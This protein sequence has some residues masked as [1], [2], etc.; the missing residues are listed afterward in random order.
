M[1]KKLFTILV[2]VVALPSCM[3][4]RFVM[5]YDDAGGLESWDLTSDGS[6]VSEVHGEI[7]YETFVDTVASNTLKRM[8]HVTYCSQLD[9]STLDLYPCGNEYENAF[10]ELQTMQTSLHDVF[11]NHALEITI[12]GSPVN[13]K[14]LSNTEITNTLYSSGI[15]FSDAE[16]ALMLYFV[17]SNWMEEDAATGIVDALGIYHHQ[18]IYDDGT[19][20]STDVC[21]HQDEIKVIHSWMLANYLY[22]ENIPL[23]VN[24]DDY[25]TGES[26][27][28][29]FIDE[30]D[31]WSM[32]MDSAISQSI[33][34]EDLSFRLP[35][36]ML[37]NASG[38]AVIYRLHKKVATKG[39]DLKVGDI[40][41]GFNDFIVGRDS[42]AQQNEEML[43]ALKGDKKFH[44]KMKRGN[45]EFI[46]TTVAKK[47]AAP[48]EDTLFIDTFKVDDN[49]IH[50]L[51]LDSFVYGFEGPID[52][53]LTELSS[54]PAE[55]MV[56][57][58]RSN[59]GGSNQLLLYLLKTLF[60][61]E[62][63]PFRIVMRDNGMMRDSPISINETAEATRY[64]Q[65]YILMDSQSLSASEHFA[66]AVQYRDNVTVL[67]NTNTYG[68]RVSNHT[69]QGNCGKS[70]QMV[71][72]FGI[73]GLG[74]LIPKSGITADINVEIP[75]KNVFFTSINDPF[76][77][78]VLS[79]EKQKINRLKIH[80][81]Q[82]IKQ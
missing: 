48:I 32:V 68:K 44:W 8:Q 16:K 1:I 77:E 37:I 56:I 59:G 12:E 76:I 2:L 14:G 24:Y 63:Q 54:Q 9:E 13:L 73:N 61:E 17:S 58:L 27:F 29:K 33:L 30:R 3:Q 5:D 62:E 23:K 11:K 79:L 28:K 35:A 40:V 72:S 19:G 43:K 60:P 67:S 49:N 36:N 69:W 57:D 42:D 6:F 31:S 7:S 38:E 52:T 53:V 75:Y 4:Q 25:K 64:S 47:E 74:R 34:H 65:F 20:N 18:K 15:D 39:I 10:V 66:N 46:V 22:V 51:K 78:K 80:S 70:Y 26:F 21:H 55:T 71:T 82:N 50:Y 81:A 45:K 41:L